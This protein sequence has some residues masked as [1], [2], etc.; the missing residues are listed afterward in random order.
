VD[1]IPGIPGIGMT[2]AARLLT[3][4]ESLDNLRANID[5]VESMKFR[6]AK[7]I[8]T[9]LQ[10]HG[11]VLDISSELTPIDCAVESMR[12]VKVTSGVA[13]LERLQQ[14]ME[15]QQMGQARRDKWMNLVENRP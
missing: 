8:M 7:R 9:L 6:G 12:E 11:S 5:Q 3:K 15:Y 2:I 10:E 4:F 1:N 13:D 14:M